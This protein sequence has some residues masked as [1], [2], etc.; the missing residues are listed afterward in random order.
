MDEG[1]VEKILK[2]DEHADATQMAEILWLNSIIS[3]KALHKTTTQDLT[4][5][6]DETFNNEIKVEKHS[7]LPQDVPHTIVIQEA[8]KNEY[9]YENDEN[10]EGIYGVYIEHEKRFPDIVK[11]FQSLKIK[12]KKFSSQEINE[13]KTADYIANTGFFYPIFKEVKKRESYFGLTIIIDT[14]ES[15][16]LWDEALNHATK[17]LLNANVFKEVSIYVFDSSKS[18]VEL[19]EML[20]GRKISLDSPLFKQEKYLTL[21]FTDVVGR[22]WR[23]KSMFTVLDM[24]SKYSL[25]TIVSMLPKRMWQKTPL[26]LGISQYLKSSKFL[27]KNSDLISEYKFVEE[28]LDSNQSKIPVIP[29]DDSAFMYLS[30]IV[31]FRKNA[32]IDSKIFTLKTEDEYLEKTQKSKKNKAQIVTARDRVERYFASTIKEARELAI[33]ASVL[34]LHHKVL[35][36]LVVLRSL[37]NDMDAFSEFY[38]GGLLDKSNSS[39]SEMYVFHHG[40]RQEL[41]NYINM[42]E[43]ED[44][45][46]MLHR[47]IASALGIKKNL[48]ELLFEHN[49]N[50]GRLES[51]EEELV[52]LLIEI[53]GTKGAFYK[54]ELNAL[55]ITLD[56][57]H[58]KTNTYQMGSNDGHD[59]EKPIHQ[60]TFDH[61]FEI[62]KTPVTFE[63]YDLYCEDN[64]DV[65]KPSDEGWGRGKRPV[66]NVSWEDAQKY[67]KWLNK[68][69]EIK[70]DSK[71]RY[72][73]PT[74]AEW[75]YACRAGTMTKWSFGDD[76]EELGNYAWYNKN[77]DS[78]TYE[79]GEKLSNPWGLH[80]MHGN[81]W[82]WC[83]DD[84]VDN[85]DETPRD[86]TA[87]KKSKD[88]NK[89][90][91]GGSCVSYSGLARSTLRFR[92]DPSDRDGLVGFRLLRTLP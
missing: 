49:H 28:S 86:G 23:N 2:V 26:R 8:S 60:I 79:V 3:S 57:I 73:L 89:V 44:V 29:Y 64:K 55:T 25:T 35:K 16:F 4:S 92:N 88:S 12:Q 61:N 24:W 75:E 54:D 65:E 80:D 14:H 71:Y 37:G 36:E 30:D 27:P 9:G 11:Q 38:F 34:P 62:A 39:N 59:D 50:M 21:I 77:S 10:S 87:Y 33:Y 20:T 68:K 53:L 13:S 15:M 46:K 72:R 91:R 82:E 47:V 56:T 76:E 58:P 22:L 42:N 18:E 52:K 5:V 41:L 51:Q 31:M 17:S 85:Y 45:Y 66:I 7:S 43:I 19:K 32:W 48:L 74:E 90:L 40:V 67:C 1:F 84:W 83:Q 6:K 63:E 81:V 78:K 69:L 70:E